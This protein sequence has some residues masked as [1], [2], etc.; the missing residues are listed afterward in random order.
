MARLVPSTTE[1]RTNG[2]LAWAYSD[3]WYVVKSGPVINHN[4]GE[5]NTFLHHKGLS[6]SLQCSVGSTP[7]VTNS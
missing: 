6:R 1:L 4:D 7:C 2:D 5:V 3:G